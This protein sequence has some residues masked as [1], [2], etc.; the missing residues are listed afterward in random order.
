MQL[1]ELRVNSWVRH[2][3]VWSTFNENVKRP[4]ELQ[5]TESHFYGHGE[6]TINLETDIEPI[7]LTAEVLLRC[8]FVWEDSHKVY[9]KEHKNIGISVFNGYFVF[10]RCDINYLHELQMLYFIKTKEELIY[11]SNE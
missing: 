5:L 10:C 11:K 7:I 1:N 3:Q 4:F 2:K 6:S 9:I 8:G